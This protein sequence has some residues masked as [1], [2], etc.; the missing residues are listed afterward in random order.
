MRQRRPT[1]ALPIETIAR[2]GGSGIRNHIH[3]HMEQ[4]RERRW[5]ARICAPTS[6][7]WRF[8]RRSRST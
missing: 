5:H 3:R 6:P 4:P 8:D 1:D 2:R 7:Q